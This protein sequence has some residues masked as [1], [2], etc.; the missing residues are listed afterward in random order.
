MPQESN[1]EPFLLTGDQ[2]RSILMHYF[3]SGITYRYEFHRNLDPKELLDIVVSKE[4]GMMGTVQNQTLPGQK[5]SAILFTPDPND[6]RNQCYQ[7]FSNKEEV[8]A[9]ELVDGELLEKLLER[10]DETDETVPGF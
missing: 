4:V 8:V 3:F 2:I 10:Y 7:A 6:D 9:Q 1:K 5:T